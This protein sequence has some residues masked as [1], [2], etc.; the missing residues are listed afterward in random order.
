MV[1]ETPVN[2]SA[3]RGAYLRNHIN[4]KAGCCGAAELIK[5]NA[6]RYDDRVQFFQYSLRLIDFDWVVHLDADVLILQVSDMR[7]HLVSHYSYFRTSQKFLMQRS[8]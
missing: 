5:L 7:I 8:L 3:I 1:S 2:V 6:Y 4:D